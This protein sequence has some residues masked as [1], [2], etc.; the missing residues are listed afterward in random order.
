[1]RVAVGLSTQKKYLS[2]KRHEHAT[3]IL[4]MEEI[5]HH[6][7]DGWN[8]TNNGM[9]TIYQLAQDFA[10]IHCIWEGTKKYVYIYIFIHLL[11]NMRLYIYILSISVFWSRRSRPKTWSGSKHRTQAIIWDPKHNTKA[12]KYTIKSMYI[13]I[14]LRRRNLINNRNHS[15]ITRLSVDLGT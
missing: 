1:M 7:K 10:T 15:K 8:P 14:C 9:F 11:N 12:R 3:N 4:W 6:Q 13:Y 2:T 5:L